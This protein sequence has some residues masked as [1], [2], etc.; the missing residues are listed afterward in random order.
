MIAGLI[1]I[2]F[3]I[4]IVF[5]F[6]LQPEEEQNQN[7]IVHKVNAKQFAYGISEIIDHRN[8]KLLIDF[9]DYN[10]TE[11]DVFQQVWIDFF[12]YN[13]LLFV[14]GMVTLG[15]DGQL[16][17]KENGRKHIIVYNPNI[18]EVTNIEKT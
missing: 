1:V 3:V 13:P 18:I 8:N 7:I 17:E 5:I 16:I 15:Y 14:R 2:S 4:V 9:I 10:E 12:R 11:K 6:Y